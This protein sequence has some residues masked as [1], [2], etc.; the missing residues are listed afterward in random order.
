MSEQ[1]KVP[2]TGGDH[3]VPYE[4]RTGKESIVYFTRDL[5][6]EG[7]QRIYDRNQRKSDGKGRH[8]AAHRRAHG[9]NIISAPPGGKPDQKQAAGRDDRGDEHLL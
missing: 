4:E 3:Y 5:S 7:L 8:Q 1:N 2:G 9:P 6:A